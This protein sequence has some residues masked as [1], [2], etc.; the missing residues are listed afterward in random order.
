MKTRAAETEN[1]EIPLSS[2]E[3]VLNLENGDGKKIPAGNRENMN[4][5][6]VIENGNIVF[7]ME[8]GP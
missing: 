4:R 8:K 3:A 1:S 6:A 2:K 7:A 5:L